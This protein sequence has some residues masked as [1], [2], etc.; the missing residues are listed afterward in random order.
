MES[1]RNA[2]THTHTHTHT[3]ARARARTQW[4]GMGGCV[5]VTLVYR[6]VGQEDCKYRATVDHTGK[7]PRL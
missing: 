2:D 7:E 3:H 6:R 5:L 4:L 1:K